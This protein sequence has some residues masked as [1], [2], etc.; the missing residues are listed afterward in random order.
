M[1]GKIGIIVGRE[2]NERVR[3]KSFILTTLL[4]PLF[5]IALIV[6]PMLIMEYSEG[7]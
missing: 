1:K 2:F 6:A 5:M 3:K 4:T 7:E